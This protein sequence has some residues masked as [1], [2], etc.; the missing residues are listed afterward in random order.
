MH[1]GTHAVEPCTCSVR[2]GQPARVASP[3]ACPRGHPSLPN[4][5]RLQ[6]VKRLTADWPAAF[7]KLRHALVQAQVRL[8]GLCWASGGIAC[9]LRSA[10]GS[11]P[12]RPAGTCWQR[13]ALRWL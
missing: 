12:S 2:Y 6:V 7:T 10:L 5:A 9:T 3:A 11:C 1:V 4:A 13:S 8:T